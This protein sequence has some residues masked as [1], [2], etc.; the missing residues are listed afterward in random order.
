MSH[1]DDSYTRVGQVS[2]EVENGGVRETAAAGEAHDPD[3]LYELHVAGLL[4]MRNRLY[5]DES[6]VIHDA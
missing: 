4:C 1:G 3:T 5:R 6:V 2:S